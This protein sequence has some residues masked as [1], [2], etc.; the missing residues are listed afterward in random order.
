MVRFIHLSDLLQPD[1]NH[2]T[3]SSSD[4]GWL[5]VPPSRIRTK[6]HAVFQVVF[7]KLWTEDV[8]NVNFFKNVFKVVLLQLDRVLDGRIYLCHIRFY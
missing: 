4:Q 3:L 5:V 6:G 2:G 8:R 7:P 1:Q